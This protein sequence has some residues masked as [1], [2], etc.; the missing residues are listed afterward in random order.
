MK[1]WMMI[2]A[3]AAA[4]FAAGACVQGKPTLTIGSS[5]FSDGGTIPVQY[6]CDGKNVSPE[7]HWSGVPQATKSLALT[8]FDPDARHGAGFWHWVDYGIDP[9]ATGAK[10]GAAPAGTEGAQSTGRT[11]YTGPCPPPGDAPHHYR[12]TLY[13]LDDTPAGTL[14]GP[15]LLDAIKGHILAQA[16]YVGR[17]GR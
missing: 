15:G 4:V 2:A 12:F 6:T 13:A 17:Y 10:E 3:C 5:S 16:V 1:V 14:D 8:V 9:S 11:G 7:L